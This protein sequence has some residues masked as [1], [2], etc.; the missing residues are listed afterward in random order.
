MTLIKSQKRNI[1]CELTHQ[2]V[3]IETRIDKLPNGN[4]PDGEIPTIYCSISRCPKKRQ[5]PYLK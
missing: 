3:T 1:Y 2:N 5:C 4:G